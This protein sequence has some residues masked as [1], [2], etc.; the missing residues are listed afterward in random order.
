MITGD[1]ER[2]GGTVPQRELPARS[3]CPPKGGLDD[4]LPCNE[5][6]KR[7][8]TPAM[9]WSWL[10][11]GG[12]LAAS[13]NMGMLYPASM[14][15]MYTAENVK[16]VR[17]CKRSCARWQVPA[18]THTFYLLGR[19]DDGSGNVDVYDASLTVLA[20]GAHENY[21]PLILRAY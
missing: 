4:S 12:W 2:E 11:L 7:A 16:R 6:R 8:H 19:R 21:L 15:T 18:G 20:L 10:T 1:A 3:A 9:R 17:V 14:F 13:N 5:K